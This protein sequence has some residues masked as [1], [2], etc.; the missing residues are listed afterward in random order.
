MPEIESEAQL[1]PEEEKAKHLNQVKEDNKEISGFE[2]RI[3]ELRSKIEQCQE[4]IVRCEDSINDQDSE[5]V[6][7][8]CWNSEHRF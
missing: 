3:K 7:I 2:G 1:S 5:Q 8:L 6:I 4:E